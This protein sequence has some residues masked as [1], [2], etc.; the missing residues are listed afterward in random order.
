MPRYF[1]TTLLLLS[2]ILSHHAANA[3]QDAAVSSDPSTEV[4]VP[5]SRYQ[6]GGLHKFFFGAHYRDVWSTPINVPKL[7]LNTFAGGLTPTKKGGGMQTKSLRFDAGDGRE[8][9]FRSLDKNPGAT[10]PPELRETV[11]EDIVQDQISS[12]HPYAA[13]VVP[14]I[15]NA[16]GVLHANPILVIMPDDPRLGEF[17]E[18]FAN[19]LGFIE[20]RPEDGPNGQAGFAGSKK[21][22]G[23]DDLFL[24]LQED[25]DDFVD[26]QAYLRARLLDIYLGDWDRHPDQ[27]RWARFEEGKKKI[28]QPIPRDRDQAFAKLDGL[29]PSFAEQRYVVKQL[30]NFA[31][32]KPDIVSLTYSGRHT[33]RKFLPR[34]NGEEFH[35]VANQFVASL[36]DSVLEHAARQLPEPVY[37]ISG[38]AL[39]SKLK[40]RR[41]YMKEAAHQYY[42][43][44]AKYVEI[45]MSDKPEYAEVHRDSD[46][47]M[48]IKIFKYDKDTGEKNDDLLWQRTFKRAETREIRLYM[49]GGKDKVVLSGN[50]RKSI[51][52][53]IIGGAG[54]DEIVDQSKGKTV[55]YDVAAN[56]QIIKG[57]NTQL[58]LGKIDSL[59][60]RHEDKPLKPDYGFE[61]KPIPFLAYTPDD[62]LFIG[63][64]QALYHYA[65]RKNPYDYKMTFR[66]NFAFATGAFRVRYTGDFV[67]VFNGVRLGVEANAAVPREVRNFHGLGN[68]APRSQSIA[69]ANDLVDFYRVRS[70]EFMFKPSL[71]FDVSPRTHIA[72]AGAFKYLNTDFEDNTFIEQS[73]PYGVEA[74]SLLELSGR[75]EVDLRDLPV[76]T[77]KG[78][79]LGAGVA[80]FPKAF[81]NDSS[82][83]KSFAEARLYV[84]PV[85]LVT[86]ALRAGGEKI[87]GAFPYY[88]AAYLGGNG[89]LR[90]FRRERF[91]GEASAYGSAEMRVFL[92]RTKV[93][94]PTDFGVFFFGD[95]GRVWLNEDEFSDWKDLHT[96]LGGGIWFAPI[97]RIFTFAIGAGNSSEGKLITAGGGFSF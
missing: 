48:T 71:R 97:Y 44:L 17:R 92:F 57:S 20:E 15:A 5:G 75:I 69:G 43:H 60:N 94:F 27:W 37:Q 29:F 23:S 77:S 51:A 18:E 95:A 21:I 13:L 91:G 9:A 49:M 72:A 85:K 34:L 53:R 2:M 58:R 50:A 88:E 41:D 22:V 16:V 35:N 63:H 78:V 83:T 73:R 10:L 65:F 11:A 12:A 26:A 42:L 24:E 3:Q 28:W 79:Y 52:V 40:Q 31:K 96:S 1:V 36:T 39:E 46:E 8:F 76:A 90:G 45:K 87:W 82:F 59:V 70:H 38:P 67:E 6:R 30:E 80:H 54:E 66:G 61:G 68:Q 32:N 55:V 19:M 93:V 86:F 25:N 89:T 4:R 47:T 74:A 81:D 33:D 62:G 64:G 14:A 56:T 84:S 7:D